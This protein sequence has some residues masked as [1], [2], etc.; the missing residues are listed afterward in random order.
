VENKKRFTPENLWDEAYKLHGSTRITPENRRHSTKSLNAAKTA[1]LAAAGRSWVVF[2]K[3]EVTA[4]PADD[5]DSLKKP[6]AKGY[7]PN[8]HFTVMIAPPYRNVKGG[9]RIF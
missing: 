9:V 1:R 2:A 7:C 4:L 3:W 8:Q 5:A 6:H